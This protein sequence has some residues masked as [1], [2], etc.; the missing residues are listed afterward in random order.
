[1]K[2]NYHSQRLFRQAE[3]YF[4][5][6]GETDWNVQTRFQG[7]TDIDLNTNGRN[8][9]GA[10]KDFFSS[11]PIRHLIS[12]DLSRARETAEIAI[13]GLAQFQRPKMIICPSLRETD[14]GA[15]EGLTAEEV[16]QTFGNSSYQRWYSIAEQDLDFR[17]PKGE[18]KRHHTA[19]LMGGLRANLDSILQNSNCEPFP[20]IGISTHGG[21]LRRILHYIRPELNRPVTIKNCVV[22]C[23]IYSFG[24]NWQIDAEPIFSP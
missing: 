24:G 18:T 4:F 20:K 1:M 3:V 12:S 2:S 13:S 21:S 7:S 5:R 16:I 10:L 14:L 8:Q 9:A 19:R 6:H 23:G 17:F 22:Y 15:A 11:R